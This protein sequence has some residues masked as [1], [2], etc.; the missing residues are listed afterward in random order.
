[1][2]GQQRLIK[3]SHKAIQRCREVGSIDG[4]IVIAV[5][6]P[7]PC[8]VTATM[9]AYKFLITVRIGVAFGTY[10]QHVLEKMSEALRIVRIVKMPSSDGYC[11]T[12]L[13]ELCFMHKHTAHSIIEFNNSI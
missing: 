5:F 3:K 10:K 9:S 8:V 7:R 12:G 1:L 11:R 6:S 2:G 4:K 13:R